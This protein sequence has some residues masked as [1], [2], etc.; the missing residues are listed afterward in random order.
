MVARRLNEYIK[1]VL[2]ADLFYIVRERSTPK[3]LIHGGLPRNKEDFLD[4]QGVPYLA[5]SATRGNDSRSH[6]IG[7]RPAHFLFHFRRSSFQQFHL[8][9][10]QEYLINCNSTRG[11]NLYP[12]SARSNTLEASAVIGAK[13][14]Q[15]IE[16]NFC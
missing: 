8:F 10:W 1:K 3:G 15:S 9:I 14:T 12:I 7:H 6:R 16:F 5:Y 11:L 4:F 13:E 2:S